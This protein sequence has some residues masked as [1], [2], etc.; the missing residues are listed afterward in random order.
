MQ[1]YEYT[2]V[3][4]GN[5]KKKRNHE[6]YRFKNDF[7]DIYLVEVFFYDFNVYAI[8]F[9][10]K[11]HRLSN[12]RYNMVY[13]KTFASKKGRKTGNFNFLK[14][15]NTISHISLQIVK[16]DPLASFGFLGAPKESELD[17]NKNAANI[18]ADCTVGNTKRYIVY[19]NYVSRYYDPKQFEYIS[20]NTSS[21][22]L[23][24]NNKNAT[25]LT[26]EVAEKYITEEIIPNL[27][28]PENYF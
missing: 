16:R 3:H 11:K 21:I 8:K 19:N 6:I 27:S 7:G 14:V 24:R 26:K 23:L 2:L 13:P 15:L 22:M 10:L 18:N 25:A 20:S 12:S 1:I 5:K 9:F 28:S 17:S 4:G